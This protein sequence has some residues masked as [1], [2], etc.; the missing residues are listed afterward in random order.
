MLSGRFGQP[1]IDFTYSDQWYPITHGD[2]YS[3]VVRETPGSQ[4]LPS[5]PDYWRPSFFGHGNPGFKDNG[6]NPGDVVVSEARLITT[7][8]AA[9]GWSCT[10]LP[11]IRLTSAVGTSART[12]NRSTSIVSRLAQ[13]CLRMG[14]SIIP[15]KRT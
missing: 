8:S 7:K 4:T 3:L 12:M 11:I 5:S 10:T 6:H 9:T 14:T 1:I 15:P 2:G 13:F